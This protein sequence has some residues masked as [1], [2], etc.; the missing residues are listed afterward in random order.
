MSVKRI[1]E[2]AVDSSRGHG[3]GE[4]GASSDTPIGALPTV[5]SGDESALSLCALNAYWPA[6]L[7]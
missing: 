3:S 4:E 2:R 1:I 5:R 6:S 7:S